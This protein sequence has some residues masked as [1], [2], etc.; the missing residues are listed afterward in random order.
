MKRKMDLILGKL[1]EKNTSNFNGLI[2]EKS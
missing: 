1:E 2:A